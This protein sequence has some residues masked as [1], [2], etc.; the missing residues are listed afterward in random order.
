[1]ATTEIFIRL[2]KSDLQ[3]VMVMLFWLGL[4]FTLLLVSY[5]SKQGS[6]RHQTIFKTLSLSR[7][8][9]TAA[10]L[11]LLLSGAEPHWI[12]F[13]ASGI[14]LFGGLYFETRTLLC[15]VAKPSKTKRTFLDSSAAVALAVLIFSFVQIGAIT[16][17]FFIL[18]VLF[19]LIVLLPGPVLMLRRGGSPL[20]IIIGSSYILLFILCV[21]G[22]VQLNMTLIPEILPPPLIGDLVRI[23]FVEISFIGGL[24][25]VLIAKED[26][27]AHIQE[28]AFR[29]PLTGLHNRRF[30]MEEARTVLS[31]CARDKAEASLIFIDIDHFKKI[32]DEHGHHF[33]DTVLRDFSAVL[34][35]I[36]R[37]LDLSCRYGGEEFL[38]L[39]P[40]ADSGEALNAALRLLDYCRSSR[41]P[42][43]PGF[44][45]TVS[46]GIAS[47]VPRSN[48]V[49]ELQ[50]LIE[51]ADKALYRAKAAGRDRAEIFG[52]SERG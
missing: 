8:M 20:K 19:C 6:E 1:M 25:I 22:I 31:D 52:E 9:Q 16:D 46:A 45:Y 51:K 18:G 7:G 35:L 50:E 26:S 29:D 12:C 21:W 42:S 11:V 33:G 34:K 48:S 28:L 38:L 13:L 27:D 5:L 14:L 44:S 17:H 3:S 40:R 10:W 24:G 23:L 49:D 37:P 43:K 41:F 47:G 4:T 39:L 2:M 32:N 30:F 36:Y 15:L